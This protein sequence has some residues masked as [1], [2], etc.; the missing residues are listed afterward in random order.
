MESD[1]A[2]VQSREHSK[3]FEKLHFQG[4]CQMNFGSS[5]S[6]DSSSGS[7]E[8]S[9]EVLVCAVLTPLSHESFPKKAG[10]RWLP[11]KG[12]KLQG[13]EG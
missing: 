11:A 2:G 6:S 10:G 4:I 1:I 7:P 9:K 12:T 8:K 5:K 3:S 13:E